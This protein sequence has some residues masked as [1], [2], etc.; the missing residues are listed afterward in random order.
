MKRLGTVSPFIMPLIPTMRGSSLSTSYHI[1][2]FV[3]SI[4]FHTVFSISAMRSPSSGYTV[5]YFHSFSII[6]ISGVLPPSDRQ[7]LTALQR[8]THFVFHYYLIGVSYFRKQETICMSLKFYTSRSLLFPL[9]NIF[10]LCLLIWLCLQCHLSYDM[11]FRSIPI[12]TILFFR[13]YLIGV[14]LRER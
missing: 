14:S 4:R 1:L 6:L 11:P 7:T 8:Y 2:S 9:D 5:Y 13:L 12:C 3:L 10:S